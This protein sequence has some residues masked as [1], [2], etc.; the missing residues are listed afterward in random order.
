MDPY[1]IFSIILIIL[2]VISFS[3]KASRFNFLK[4]S[5]SVAERNE[6]KLKSAALSW[7][8]ILFSMGG[9]MILPSINPEPH[10]EIY[11]ILS[12]TVAY[13]TSYFVLI[14]KESY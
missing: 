5:L 14:N 6:I 3:T 4:S 7:M 10:P 2:L 13:F 9:R 8:C 11:Y 12:G 1:I